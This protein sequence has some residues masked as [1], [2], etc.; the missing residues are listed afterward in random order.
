MVVIISDEEWVQG[1][2]VSDG[3]CSIDILDKKEK[4]WEVVENPIEK[5]N[6]DD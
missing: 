2:V 1:K 4:K 3:K 5:F 6:D